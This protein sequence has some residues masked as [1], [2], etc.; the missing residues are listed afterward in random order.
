MRE[1]VEQVVDEAD[2]VL[3]LP[4]DHR[5]L[6]RRAAAHPHQRDRRQDRREG[7]AQLVPQHREELVLR[8]V[9]ALGLGA[10]LLGLA[11]EPG[12]LDGHRGAVGERRREGEVL[13]PVAALRLRGGE[14][15]RADG[16][17][18]H[19]EGHRE[20]GAQ[21]QRAQEPQVLRVARGGLEGRLG[22]VR[23]HH[24]PA[25]AEDLPHG[26]RGDR[27]VGVATLDLLHHR[28]LRR[29]DV[30]HR[31][32]RHAAALQQVDRRP[33]GDLRHREP[34]HPRE[35]LRVV[36]RRA[37]LLRGAGDEPPP[38]LLAAPLRHVAE[39]RDHRVGPPPGVV[40]RLGAHDGPVLL[41]G[42]GRAE[43][44]HPL[45]RDAG[46]QCLAPGHL[47]RGYRPPV[48][49]EDLE[50]QRR[51]GDRRV[52]ERVEGGK[53][54]HRRGALVGVEDPAG[55]ALHHD[56]VVDSVEDG[57]ELAERRSP[58]PDAGERSLAAARDPRRDDRDGDR[59]D[60]EE[61][62]LRWVAAPVEAGREDEVQPQEGR[63]RR[64][65]EP[66]PQAAVPRGH[67]HGRGVEQEQRRPPP[68]GVEGER[69]E[70]QQEQGRRRGEDA[71]HPRG[72][73]LAP[74][75][76]SGLRSRRLG[77]HPLASTGDV[78]AAVLQR[79]T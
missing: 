13:G 74:G 25:R 6:R 18:A 8:A 16:R 26:A 29:V 53:S 78:G 32:P 12:V 21:P 33:V 22:D 17:A 38:D 48:L 62:E 9:G 66:G 65:R 20:V 34:R 36:E 1:H 51:A 15:Q 59:L 42:R 69:G 5:G 68:V 56:A 43:E 64:R 72:P 55:G 54:E 11:V 46:A 63:D 37:Q 39:H 45:D 14:G 52:E 67:E 30:R 23:H 50:G 41:A 49:V 10:G 4:L 70:G 73:G 35:R 57:V 40:E 71:P 3:H 79:V 7:V 47:R 31:E 44:Q 60:E 24:R 19:Q 77:L 27:V 58:L 75:G 2:D 28:E 76:F 61:R